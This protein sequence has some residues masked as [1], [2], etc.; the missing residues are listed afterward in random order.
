MKGELDAFIVL[1][2][3]NLS[4][5]SSEPKLFCVITSVADLPLIG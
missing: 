2:I 5:D 4:K 3:W 1:A